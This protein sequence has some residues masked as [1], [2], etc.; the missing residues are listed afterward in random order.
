M[1]GFD[2]YEALVFMSEIISNNTVNPGTYHPTCKNLTPLTISA[3]N[4]LMNMCT[5]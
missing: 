2:L 5:G 3:T 4:H 1:V